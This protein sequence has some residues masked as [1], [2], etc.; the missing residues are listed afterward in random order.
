[1]AFSASAQIKNP[2][3]WHST[4]EKR[5][6]SEYILNFEATIEKGWHLYSQFTPEGGPAP[7]EILFEDGTNKLIQ[8]G[9][10]TESTTVTTYNKIFGVDETYFVGKA[11]ISQRI[12]VVNKSSHIS[13]ITLAYQICKQVCVPQEINFELDV[14][15]LRMRQIWKAIH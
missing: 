15:L 1:M 5:S 11:K 12:K 2:V 10:A 6:N 9:N 8:L 7:L 3:S 14:K 13:H 4:V